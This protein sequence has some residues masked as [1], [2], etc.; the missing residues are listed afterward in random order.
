MYLNDKSFPYYLANLNKEKPTVLRGYPSGIYQLC[1]YVEQINSKLEFKIQAIYLTSENILD[2]QIELIQRVF[3]CPIWGQY[4]HSEASIFATRFPNTKSY[5][6]N[7]IYGVTEVLDSDGNHVRAGEV[8]EIV[9]TGFQYCALPFIRY[10]TGDLAEF[11]GERNGVITLNKLL[12]RSGDYIINHQ[13]EK[14]FLVGFIFGGHLN[15][16]NCI[17]SWQ[18]IQE[19]EGKLNI[20]IVKDANY[21]E[22]DEAELIRLF[23]D[24]GF[25]I[26]IN[27]VDS[28]PK[29]S[30]GKQPFMI[31][32]IPF[33]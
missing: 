31:Q 17:D 24:N 22:S 13:G 12:G 6:C 16:F 15:A 3:G 5:E 30:R 9:V 32:K 14:I 23:S 7:P 4:G 21:T 8:G 10:R 20:I 2:Y 25:R 18:I 19:K 28:I 1:K 26:C 33:A 29:T 27:Y 11:G